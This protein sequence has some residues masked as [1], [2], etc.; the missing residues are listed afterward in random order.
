M[1]ARTYVLTGLIF[2]DLM[3]RVLPFLSSPSVEPERSR[4]V[5]LPLVPRTPK[6][7]GRIDPWGEVGEASISSGD[8]YAPS[9]FCLF[10]RD[11]KLRKLLES[12]AEEGVSPPADLSPPSDGE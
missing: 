11:R 5:S 12:L 4:L 10:F 6:P 3:F 2:F 9:S 7:T 1:V 8:G